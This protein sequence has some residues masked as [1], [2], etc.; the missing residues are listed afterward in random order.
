[1]KI[2]TMLSST[3]KYSYEILIFLFILFVWTVHTYVV[4]EEKEDKDV[5]EFYKET[6]LI[7]SSVFVLCWARAI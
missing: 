5:R 1:M 2:K 4:R 7:R 6:R 3:R